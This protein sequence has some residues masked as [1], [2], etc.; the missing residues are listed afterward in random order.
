M[1]EAETAAV[2]CPDSLPNGRAG[3]GDTS[4]PWH[5][6]VRLWYILRRVAFYMPLFIYSL[7]EV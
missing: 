6:H 3:A 5:H 2:F 1:G 4:V 7:Y